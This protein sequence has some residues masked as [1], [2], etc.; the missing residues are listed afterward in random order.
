MPPIE[1]RKPYK[2]LWHSDEQYGASPGVEKIT[3]EEVVMWKSGRY[4]GSHRKEVRVSEGPVE[5]RRRHLR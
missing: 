3:N 1:L 4:P 2:E 5:V